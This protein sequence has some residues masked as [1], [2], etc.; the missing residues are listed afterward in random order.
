MG[1]LLLGLMIL[2]I[3]LYKRNKALYEAKGPVPAEDLNSPDL[4]KKM[5]KNIKM[6]ENK[7]KHAQDSSMQHD[8]SG[9]NMDIVVSD[10]DPKDEMP[11]HVIENNNQSR[12]SVI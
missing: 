7:Y 4:F 6:S 1:V 5:D 8:R 12:S 11:Y 10:M 9:D 3:Y 2:A